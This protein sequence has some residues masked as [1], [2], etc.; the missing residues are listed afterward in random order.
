MRPKSKERQK[1]GQKH[2]TCRQ[3]SIELSTRFFRETEI[4]QTCR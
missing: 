2:L 3:P 4:F 1:A